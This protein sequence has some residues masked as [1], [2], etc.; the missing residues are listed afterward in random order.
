MLK[1]ACRRAHILRRLSTLK[2]V[3]YLFESREMLRWIQFRSWKMEDIII[4]T[5]AVQISYRDLKLCLQPNTGGSH[6]VATSVVIRH[7]IVRRHLSPTPYPSPARYKRDLGKASYPGCTWGRLT[8]ESR[9][10]WTG[11]ESALLRYL[12]SPQTMITP[13]IRCNRP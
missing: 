10:V 3:R 6:H 2:V 11:D 9:A 13:R 1:L 12:L 5:D 7:S 4:R 8:S